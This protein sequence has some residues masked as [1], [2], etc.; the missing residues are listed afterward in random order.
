DNSDFPAL[1]RYL[2]NDDPTYRMVEA[3]RMAEK[4]VVGAGG[5]GRNKA[6]GW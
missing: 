4:V 3:V 6:T 2:A 5:I 1:L